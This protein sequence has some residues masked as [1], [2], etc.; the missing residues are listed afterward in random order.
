MIRR[1]RIAPDAIYASEFLLSLRQVR[2]MG[3]LPMD[4][5]ARLE[6]LGQ[7]SRLIHKQLLYSNIMYPKMTQ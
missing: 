2:S 7:G 1:H 5:R 6:K 4:I 3:S